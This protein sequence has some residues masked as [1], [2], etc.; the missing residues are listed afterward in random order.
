MI[1]CR[2][3]LAEA[4]ALARKSATAEAPVEEKP[5]KEQG[6]ND[7]GAE[8]REEIKRLLE[9]SGAESSWIMQYLLEDQQKDPESEKPW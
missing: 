2:E 7:E 6:V 3:K 9:E 4:K 8:K 1:I 5:V